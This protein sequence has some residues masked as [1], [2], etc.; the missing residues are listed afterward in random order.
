MK[1]RRR[2]R[3]GR[4]LRESCSEEDMRRRASPPLFHFARLDFISINAPAILR[5]SSKVTNHAQEWNRF[6]SSGFKLYVVVLFGPVL[7]ISKHKGLSCNVRKSSFASIL[8]GF[9]IQ[10][11]INIHQMFSV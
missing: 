6:S 10:H 11:Y 1:R 8:F 9:N 5:S 4:R 2:R 7:D 3:K